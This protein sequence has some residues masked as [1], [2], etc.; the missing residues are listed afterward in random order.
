[1]NSTRTGHHRSSSRAVFLLGL[2]ALAIVAACAFRAAKMPLVIS[3]WMAA[4]VIVGALD[5]D[6]LLGGI[7][8]TQD[9]ALHN[10]TGLPIDRLREGNEV[11]SSVKQGTATMEKLVEKLSNVREKAECKKLKNE[12]KEARLGNTF[13]RMQNERVEKDLYWTR[14]RA[15]EFYQEMIRR[16]F[17]FEERPN[18]AINIPTEDEKSPSS[19][20]QRSPHDSLFSMCHDRIMPLKS[21]PM[22]QAAIRRLVKESVDAAIAAKQE[23]QAKVRNDASGSGP[24]RGRDTAP[25]VRECTFAGFMKCNPAVFH[26]VEGVVELRRWFKKT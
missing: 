22:T 9:N 18:E 3:C 6:V 19:E 20:P 17:M 10:K 2:L 1:M 8:S 26:G 11:R 21:A 23:R 14:V 4:K 7:L 12:L 24:V 13:L 16:G 5:V 25:A 15:H